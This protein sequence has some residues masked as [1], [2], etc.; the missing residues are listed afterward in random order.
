LLVYFKLKVS[1]CGGFGTVVL[2]GLGKLGGPLGADGGP[3]PDGL[4]I[5]LALSGSLNGVWSP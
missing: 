3:L 1:A 5:V 4:E 2:G